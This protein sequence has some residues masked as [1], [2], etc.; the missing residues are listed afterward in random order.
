MFD[1]ANFKL[2]VLQYSDDKNEKS[3]GKSYSNV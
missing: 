3:L 2:K 1:K